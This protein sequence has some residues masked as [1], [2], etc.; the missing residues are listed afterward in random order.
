MWSSAI[1]LCLL[2]SA[3]PGGE[4]TAPD[5]QYMMLVPTILHI[6]HEERLC[7]ILSHLNETIS[8]SVILDVGSQN[9]TLLEKQVTESNE[10]F[11]VTFQ[12]PD[13][14]SSKLAYFTL[15]ADGETFHFRKRRSVLL[16]LQEN[17]VF[18]QTDKSIYKPG[19][20]V[21]FRI[22]SLNENFYAVSENFPL[23]YIEDPQRN[24]IAQW[25][26]VE[27]NRGITQ[28]SFQLAPEPIHGTYKVVV[29][30]PKGQQVQH[31]FSVEEYVLPRYEVQVKLPPVLTVEDEEFSVTVCGKY[32][33]GKPVAGMIKVRI[34]RQFQQSYS[35]CV[36]YEDGVCE[37]LSHEAGP[38]GC[39]SA[40]VQTKLFQLKRTGY[41]MNIKA[42]AKIIEEGTGVEL[43]GESSTEI[44]STLAKVS[45]RQ[46]D[47]YYKTGIPTYGQVFLEDAAGNPLTNETVTIFVGHDGTN[48]TYT[49][50]P[51][52]TADFSIDTT[53]WQGHSV[54]LR[55]SY[56]TQAYCSSYGW[57]NPIYEEQSLPVRR[58]YSRS[59][60]FL[61]VKPIHKTLHCET[62]QKIKVHYVLTSMGIGTTKEAVFRYVIMSKGEIITSKRHTVLLIEN[63]DAAGHFS[64]ELPVKT[65]IAPLAKVLVFLILD[66]GEVIAD[67][68][69]VKVDNCFQNKVKLSFSQTQSL[70]GSETILSLQTD[71]DSL[72]AI[73]AVDSSVL[74]MRPEAELS[75]KSVYDLL[76]LKDLSGYHYDGHYMEEPHDEP[77]VKADPIFLNGFYY[78]PSSPDSDIDAYTIL[79]D[80]GLKVFTNT[81]I[82]SPT[83]CYQVQMGYPGAGIAY[84]TQR[85]LAMPMA[86]VQ[87][88]MLSGS[89]E[90]AGFTIETERKYFPETWL[91]NFELTDSKGQASIPLTVPDTI[92]TWKAGMFCT[93]PHSGFG[94]SETVSHVAMQPFFLELTVPYSAVRGEE[95]LIQSTVFNYLTES[96]EVGISLENT[97][98]YE[99]KAAGGKEDGYCIDA[100]KKVTMSWNVKLKTL[101]EINFTVSAETL[102]GK[103]VCGNQIA[104]SLP[105]RKDTITRS[106]LVEPEGVE[107]E[108][109]Q[110]SM[111]CGKGSDISEQF[112]LQ[113][114]EHVVEGSARGYFSVIGDIMGTAMQNLGSLLKMP[115][116]CG[117]QNMVLFTPNIYILEYLNNTRQLTP[118]LESKALSYLNS[119][120][121]KQLSYKHYDGSYSA[122]GP[123]YGG[124]NTW[125]TAF[126]MKSFARAR[127]QIYIEEKQISDP[128]VWLT[129]QQK[130]NGCFRSVGTLFN[131]AMKG[132]VSDEVTLS[133]YITIALLEYP[134]P[135]S[136]HV[137]R[138]ALFCL[139]NAIAGQ[140]NIHTE[141]MMAY[142]FTLAR[143]SDISNQLFKHLDEQAIKTDDSIHWQRPEFSDDS[144][145][146]RGSHKLAPSAEV[147]MNSYA[148]L[149]TLSK[150]E[151][152]EED[153]TFATK[154]VNWIIKQRNP[155]GGFSSTQDTVVALQ[156]LSLFGSLT[157]GNDAPRTVSLS[158][159]GTPVAKFHVED[160]NRLLLQTVPLA[161][162]PGDYTITVGGSGCVFIQANLKYNLPHPKGDAPFFISVETDPAICNHKSEKSFSIAVNVSYTGKRE[163]SNMAIVEIKLPS[164]YIPIKSSVRQL[165]HYSN[166]KRTESFPNKVTV[167]FESLSK[168]IENFEFLVEQD[169]PVGNLQPSTAKVY[170]YYETDEFAVTKYSAPCSSKEDTSSNV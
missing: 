64:F 46:V 131:N 78:N 47:S 109:T 86:M 75:A 11:C 85:M 146:S 91:W 76:P 94:L 143:K 70:P 101:G 154:I 56:K 17:L 73:R 26:N 141:A 89:V 144:G 53:S 152:S 34:C 80:M 150:P 110:N 135:T 113:L 156:A 99:A 96:I 44:K 71:P 106:M 52:G 168:R 40:V 122:F 15:D 117:E 170:D 115:F 142:A 112:S 6:G 69:S 163:N 59:N 149:A 105:R 20:K 50:G 100:N 155:N 153:L 169:I 136:H 164:G 119:G 2:L 35:S 81:N 92:T 24:R 93:S 74:L 61:K 51:D 27:T 65:N 29:K 67:S 79:K 140:N 82:K 129:N 167:Y 1:A 42:K 103:G 72:C 28:E 126:V 118:E 83:L 116:G 114:P 138:N 84:S 62:V 125:L 137:V 43:T 60:S 49:T 97:D 37:E 55:A 120:Y 165:A 98:Q 30:R 133:T 3:L 132:G 14:D 32:T 58:F 157:Q 145:L 128:L 161:K 134:L 19:Q 87:E 159:A 166:I 162:V 8:V 102:P 66:S 147:E 36:G 139:E 127:S 95:L 7:L 148:L 39:Y 12:I 13:I 158:L 48:F 23:V 121:Q 160:S 4:P 54:Q 18:V 107:K 104:H 10:D 22:A 123:S 88:D 108:E 151:I 77:C 38:D 33:Y 124:G 41:H 5:P 90:A 45:F 111:I 57:V 68:I 16:K 25:L 21:Q 31:T 9:L 63:Q 130:D